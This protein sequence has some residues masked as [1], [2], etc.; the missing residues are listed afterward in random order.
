MITQKGTE[1]QGLNIGE[2]LMSSGS[3]R[4]QEDASLGGKESSCLEPERQSVSGTGSEDYSPPHSGG[5]SVPLLGPVF[6]TAKG[7]PEQP[8]LEVLIL[9]KKGADF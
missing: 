2:P 8:P 9:R 5:F 6:P 4:G 7:A 3:G 1:P